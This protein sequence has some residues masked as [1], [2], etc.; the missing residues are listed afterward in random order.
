M[1]I[2]G[3]TAGIPAVARLLRVVARMPT[4]QVVL[5]QLDLGMDD[6][7]WGALEPSHAAG[8]VWRGCW[9]DLDATRGDVRPWDARRQRRRPAGRA[10]RVL[11]RALLPAQRAARLAGSRPR[12]RWTGCRA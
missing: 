7:A 3:T 4:G 9:S 12:R 5:P 2:A 6:E 11:S 1:L 10:S 8:R